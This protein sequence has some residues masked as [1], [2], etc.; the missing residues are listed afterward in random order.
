MATTIG[1][2][3]SEGDYYLRVTTTIGWLL[4]EGDYYLRVATI[5]GWLLS[6]ARHLTDEIQCNVLLY[7]AKHSRGETFTFRVENGYSLENFCSSMLVD[8]HS[9]STRP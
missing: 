9:Q 8:L 2:L 5:I 4:S 7:T 6:K 1:W 3:L